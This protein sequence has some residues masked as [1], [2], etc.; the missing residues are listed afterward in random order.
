MPEEVYFV[1]LFVG[2]LMASRLPTISLKAVHV[3]REWQRFAVAAGLFL[4]GC[5]FFN[6]WLTLGV[7][8]ALYILTVPLTG[9]VFLKVRAAYEAAPRPT[10]ADAPDRAP[11]SEGAPRT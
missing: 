5:L 11:A 8:G 6:L 10:P 1:L 9:L 4:I 7:V 3:P 2:V